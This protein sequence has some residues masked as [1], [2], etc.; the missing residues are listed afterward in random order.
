[1]KRKWIVIAV[2]I[3][4]FTACAPSAN[5]I[6]T[7]I[8]QTQA[9]NPTATITA[10]LPTLT[11]TTTQTYTR[12]ITFAPTRTNTP[13]ITN[14]PTVTFTATI[15]STPTKTSTPTQTPSNTPT[16]TF[17]PSRTPTATFTPSHTPTKTYTPTATLPANVIGCIPKNT[18]R[19]TGLV[20]GVIDGD[21][22]DVRINNQ[23]YRVRYIGMDT[24][25]RNET[26]Y[27]QSTAYNQKLVSGK[28]VTLVKDVSETDRFD[29]LLRYIIVGERFVNYE[30][31][32]QGYAHASAYPPDVACAEAFVEAQRYAQAGKIGLWKPAPT[33]YVPPA[34]GGGSGGNCHPAYPSVCI[35]PAPPDLDCKDISYRRF[36]VLPPDP[37]RFDGDSDGI[38]CES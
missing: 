6:N 20:I 10:P 29:R 17:T 11:I 37:H 3:L 31:V 15:T 16:R 2:G 34:G 32:E 5:A 4:I 23:V 9:A 1:M 8:A 38:G 22:I 30:I 27:S 25:E 18:T 13:T 7:A 24:P 12:T 14:T 26:F 19:E 36:Q 28:I 35:P 33:P 21:T